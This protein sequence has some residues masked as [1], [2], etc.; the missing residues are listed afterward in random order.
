MSP[1]DGSPEQSSAQDNLPPVQAPSGAFV[2]QLFIVPAVIVGVIAMLYGLFFWWG[3]VRSDDA[4]K[5]VQALERDNQARWQAAV[6]LA[7]AL[8]DPRNVELKKNAD[9]AAKLASVLEREIEAGQTDKSA[10]QLRI[11]L[12]HALGEFQVPDGVPASA[13]GGQDRMPAGRE[14]RAVS[15]HSRR[16]P[17]LCRSRPSRARCASR[18]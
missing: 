13:V 5:Y 11:Y 9:I 16:W 7:D 1:P 8:R 2:L 12:C 4:E 10:L 6:N 17:C 3:Q 18:S 14:I 15:Q